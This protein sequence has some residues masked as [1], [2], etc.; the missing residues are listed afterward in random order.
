MA[1][2]R[3][4]PKSLKKL[5]LQRTQI[6]KKKSIKGLS[7]SD[8]LSLII[9]NRDHT[10][11]DSADPLQIYFPRQVIEFIKRIA[12]YENKSVSHYIRDIMY[13]YLE[14]NHFRP[15][16]DALVPASTLPLDSKLP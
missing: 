7:S 10:I 13:T 4:D 9:I 15:L 2:P 12:K 3:I 8:Q 5:P 1:R 16:I 6:R 11:A 14:N